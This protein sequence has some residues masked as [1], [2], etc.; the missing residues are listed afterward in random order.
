[1]K[2]LLLLL[3]FCSTLQ[4]TE[5]YVSP[6]GTAG[7]DGTIGDPWD[8][9]TAMGHPAAVL[10]GDT[11]WLRGGTHDGDDVTSTLNGS[12]GSPIIV[13]QFVGERAIIDVGPGQFQIATGSSW[14]DYWGFEVTSSNTVRE[15]AIVGSEPA[16]ITHSSFYTFGSNVNLINLVVHDLHQNGIGIWEQAVNSD[17][18]GCIIY[19]NGW[20][21]PD[22]GH[23]QG[24]YIQN[25]AGSTKNLDNIISFNNLSTGMKGFGQAGAAVNLNFSQ[26]ISFRNGM[27]VLPGTD[28]P[29]ENLF[30]GTDIVP[31]DNITMTT[32]YLYHD[33]DIGGINVQMGWNA[34]DNG[35][36]SLTNSYLANASQAIAVKE[37]RTITVT[38]NTVFMTEGPNPNSNSFIGDIELATSG[39]LSETWDNNTY[40]TTKP[41]QSDAVR[42]F[43]YEGAVNEFGSAALS[44]AQWQ[45]DPGHDASSTI[46]LTAPTTNSVFV[47]PNTYEA[48]RAH[49]AIFNWEGLSTVSVDIDSIGLTT[50]EAFEV[51]DVENLFGTAILTGSYDGSNILIPMTSTTVSATVGT[52]TTP[53]THSDSEF[54]AFLIRRPNNVITIGGTLADGGTEA[55]IVA[56]SE[57]IM[58]FLNEII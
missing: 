25:E 35:S 47:L 26:I 6:T 41:E 7:G 11:I 52:F 4:A 43:F 42:T 13:R 22:R 46:T 33:A 16:D 57:T 44:F 10:A 19:N 27:M 39:S 9:V 49:I 23:G 53:P 50:G 51:M 45:V 58:P 29:A 40:F 28:S 1:M 2:K 21:A 18:Y 30:V 14:T 17:V 36:I 15:T 5:H 12:S 56:G 34:I 24:L 32:S 8:L 54:G 48:G 31:T 37:T 38:G 55:E 3:F 20:A